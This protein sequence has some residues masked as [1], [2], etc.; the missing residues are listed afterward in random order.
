MKMNVRVHVC[1][2][3][4]IQIIELYT[5]ANVGVEGR[6]GRNVNY[7]YRVYIALASNNW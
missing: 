5:H 3:T 4:I 2:A 7:G 6:R 1:T